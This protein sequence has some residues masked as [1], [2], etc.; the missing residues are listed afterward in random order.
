M[1]TYLPNKHSSSPSSF[2]MGF[3]RHFTR[4]FVNVQNTYIITI[5]AWNHQCA[6]L[7]LFSLNV[8][9]LRETHCVK[10]LGYFL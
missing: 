7:P 4:H 1:H 3:I 5:V 9:L 10:Y 6:Q 8:E 2:T